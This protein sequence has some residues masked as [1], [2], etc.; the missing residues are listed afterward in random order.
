MINTEQVPGLP[1]RL[2]DVQNQ[3]VQVIIV[4][5]PP[6]SGSNKGSKRKLK[7]PRRRKQKS[8]S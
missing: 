4:E 2:A 3:F 1:V 7:L 5:I 8:E 6:L